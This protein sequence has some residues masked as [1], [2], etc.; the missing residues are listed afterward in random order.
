MVLPGGCPPD[1]QGITPAL[2]CS[3]SRGEIFDPSLSKNWTSLGNYSLGVE[4]NL[5]YYFPGEY[6]L[7]TVALGL[8][9]GT[10]EPSLQGQVVAGLETY[11]YYTG[12]FGLGD[13]P[14]NLTASA[15]SENLTG[16]ISH[17]SFLTTMKN[18]KL[19]PS[20]SWAYTAGAFYRKFVFS[21]LLRNTSKPT[22]QSLRDAFSAFLTT[23]HIY[24]RYARHL[25]LKRS[26]ISEFGYSWYLVFNADS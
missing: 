12:L 3:E 23:A 26:Y 24:E 11:D 22:I 14:V 6:G 19:I 2:T 21:S 13:Q 17:P 10:G 4:T 1:T 20:R 25:Y 9:N 7:D 16:T 8:T 5:G 18:Q 15:D